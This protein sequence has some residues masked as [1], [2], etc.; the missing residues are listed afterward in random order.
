MQETLWTS[1]TA[2]RYCPGLRQR[3]GCRRCHGRIRPADGPRRHAAVADQGAAVCRRCSLAVLQHGLAPGLSNPRKAGQQA[4]KRLG[5]AHIFVTCAAVLSKDLQN[6]RF[7][8]IISSR[9]AKQEILYYAAPRGSKQPAFPASVLCGAGAFLCKRSPY[10]FIR[11]NKR[12]FPPPHGA[13][14][15]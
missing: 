2:D 10:A 14:W 12:A 5:M 1:A 11:K 6:A 3:G 13:G 4:Q 9:N 7:C 15:P 8:V